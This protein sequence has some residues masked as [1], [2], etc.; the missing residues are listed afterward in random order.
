MIFDRPLPR[1][2]MTARERNQII[3]D[4]TF[5][6]LCLDWTKRHD[7]SSIVDENAHK[8]YATEENLQ[9]NMWTFGDMNILIRHQADGEIAENVSSL[10]N[11]SFFS[12][13]ILLCIDIKKIWI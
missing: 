3:Y 2:E 13:L 8:E 5:K 4:L 11:Q 1:E 6:S 9:Y 10:R 7:I 12:L